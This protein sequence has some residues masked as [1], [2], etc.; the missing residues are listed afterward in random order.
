[1]YSQHLHAQHHGF[2]DADPFFVLFRHEGDPVLYD[3]NGN[4]PQKCFKLFSPVLEHTESVLYGK[5]SD[6]LERS[7]FIAGQPTMDF[8]VDKISCSICN[9][10]A[11]AVLPKHANST[12]T[13]RVASVTL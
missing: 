8:V 7:V 11:A 1:M 3:S 4:L 10:S 6:K 12:M 13:R 5:G 9:H 2:H